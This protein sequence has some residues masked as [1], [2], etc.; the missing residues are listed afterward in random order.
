MQLLFQA[1]CLYSILLG[2]F[3]IEIVQQTITRMK[4][5]T[6]AHL[7]GPYVTVLSLLVEY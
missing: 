5:Q 2:L 3:L 4:T 6:K 7:Q 1:L